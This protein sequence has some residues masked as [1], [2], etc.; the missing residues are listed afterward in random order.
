MM[1]YCERVLKSLTEIVIIEA[2][3]K[4]GI[5]VKGELKWTNRNRQSL[6]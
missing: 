4:S 5:V 2:Q 1:L 6:T 3:M